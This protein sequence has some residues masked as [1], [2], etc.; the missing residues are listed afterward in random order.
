MIVVDISLAIIC[1]SMSPSDV[2]TCSN[3]LVGADTPKGVYNLQE[4]LTVDP[5]YGGNV[6]QFKEDETEVY[7]I[8]RLWLGRKN[9]HREKRILSKNP[10]NRMIT[11]G[12]INVTSQT[13]EQLLKCCSNETLFIK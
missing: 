12:C 13:Y 11:K 4:R 6:L 2:I 7:A 10:K 3:A 5:F 1:F 8:H 9:E